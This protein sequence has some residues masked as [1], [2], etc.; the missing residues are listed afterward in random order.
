MKAAKAFGIVAAA[1]LAVLMGAALWFDHA[2]NGMKALPDGTLIYIAQGS[3]VDKIAR[4]LHAQGVIGSPLAFKI[5]ARAE[6]LFSPVRGGLKAGE[7]ALPVAVSA[8]DVLRI[9]HMGKTFQRRLTIP[10][11]LMAIEIVALVNS[12]SVLEGEV[13]TIPAEGS[14]LPETYHFSRGMTRDEM[15]SR[16]EKSMQATLDELWKIRAPDLP[17]RTKEEAVNLAAIVEKE[18]AIAAERPR[19]AGVFVNRLRLGMKLQTDPTVIYALTLGKERLNRPL[20]RKDLDID[21]PYNTY[22]V[23]GLPP[24]PIAN[25]GYASLAAVMNPERHDYIY[26]VADGSG[27]HAFGKTLDEHNRNVM[28]WRRVQR[29]DAA[30]TAPPK[31]TDTTATTPKP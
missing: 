29:G 11:G 12:A 7:Y 3:S 9:L 2:F 18:T 31:S 30:R 6:R 4:D 17:I 25:P 1:G 27:G 20:L 22:K 23:V 15:I 16:M 21:S 26:F 8:R 14:L 10:E 5:G 13:T 24:G 28:Q 19:V